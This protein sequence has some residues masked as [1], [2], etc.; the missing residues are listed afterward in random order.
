MFERL[1]VKESAV[2][3]HLAESHA[4]NMAFSRFFNNDAV[5]P[6]VLE[7][8]LQNKAVE[9]TVGNHLLCFQDTTEI[10][11]E[12]HRKLYSAD[13]SDLGPTGNN[14]DIGFFVH[15][16]LL[17]NTAGYFPMGFSSVE[18][19]NRKWDKQDKRDRKYQ[20][21][22][23]EEKESYRWISSGKTTKDLLE[24]QCAHLTIIGDRESDIY[25]EFDQLKSDKCDVLVRSK[26]N[27]VLY[28]SR[29]RLYECLASQPVAGGYVIEIRDDQRRGHIGRKA[30]IEIRYCKVKIARPKNLKSASAPKFIELTAIEA[31]E[32]VGA[33]ESIEPVLWRL[34]TTHHVPD[35]SVALL[36][37][38]WYKTRWLIEE[39]FR[40]LKT[41]G[42]NIEAS[43]L[44]SGK[45]LKS[46]AIL[47]LQAVLRILQL[48]QD[49]DG[50]CSMHASVAFSPDEIEF[51]KLVGKHHIK[52][53]TP[54]QSNPF[55]ECSLA[56]IGWIIARLGGWKAYRS[57]ASPGVI[58]LKRGMQKFDQ[59]FQGF[60]IIR[61]LQDVYKE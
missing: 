43:Q 35:V 32:R 50:L 20:Q 18:C 4:D 34:L 55:D 2:M 23:I 45:A 11:K 46:L 52:S 9:L 59:M 57:T 10:N 28:G 3:N 30:N 39:V 53:T 27:R 36:M 25:E 31:R 41:Q 61:N 1:S 8:V 37:V 21:Q 24:K 5:Q 22:P 26:E 14:K 38:E 13:D 17:V 60:L 48:R 16:V 42:L 33:E 44:Q 29:E 19:W 51:A 58:T 7:K 6:D 15:P 47:G 54:L 40:L 56:W 49:R 12:H